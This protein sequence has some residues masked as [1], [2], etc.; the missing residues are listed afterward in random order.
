MTEDR[1]HA[2]EV[3][4]I[5]TGDERLRKLANELNHPKFVDGR[6]RSAVNKK[7]MNLLMA[8][9]DEKSAML[10]NSAN[11]K[12]GRITGKLFF[13][14]GWYSG[15]SGITAI[16]TEEYTKKTFPEATKG[17][18]LYHLDRNENGYYVPEIA[19]DAES[20]VQLAN[21]RTLKFAQERETELQMLHQLFTVK[22][23]I[24]GGNCEIKKGFQDLFELICE[25]FGYEQ[26]PIKVPT[27][28]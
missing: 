6:H 24:M 22:E 20:I 1:L 23:Q 18:R 27:M 15:R 12:I 11:K 2:L 25:Y 19:E 10:L 14:G 9:I 3:E 28:K 7:L 26:Q 5:E 21:E 4:L 8:M 16:E 17:H 13:D